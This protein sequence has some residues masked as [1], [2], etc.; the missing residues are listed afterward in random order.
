MSKSASEA[1]VEGF[2]IQDDTCLSSHGNKRWGL[3]FPR[4]AMQLLGKPPT[5]RDTRKAW[6]RYLVRNLECAELL[7]QV[8]VTK[9]RMHLKC[10]F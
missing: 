4:T 10:I 9:V 5:Y 2:T 6:L 1:D 3:A 7:M 8:T